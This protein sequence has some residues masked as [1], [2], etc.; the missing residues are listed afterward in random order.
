MGI[1]LWP[2]TRPCQSVHEV[3]AP[4]SSTLL[5]ICLFLTA[6]RAQ[7]Y[8]PSFC[9]NFLPSMCFQTASSFLF[10]TTPV[11]LQTI[12]SLQ[13]ERPQPLVRQQYRS[14]TRVHPTRL[15]DTILQNY[16]SLQVNITFL[17]D[18]AYKSLLPP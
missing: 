10:S 9:S 17:K 12:L 18:N 11:N 13:K 8:Q 1:E 6:V 7:K 15:T 4:K 3:Q 16:S 5:Q 2:S 14:T